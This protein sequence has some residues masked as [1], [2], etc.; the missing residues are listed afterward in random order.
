M[1]ICLMAPNS[2][3]PSFF[4]L[5]LFNNLKVLTKHQ[6][7]LGFASTHSLANSAGSRPLPLISN[8]KLLTSSA[9]TEKR[10]KNSAIAGERSGKDFE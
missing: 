7:D 6:H 2:L 8:A 3:E 4:K 1:F 10:S 5:I 9:V